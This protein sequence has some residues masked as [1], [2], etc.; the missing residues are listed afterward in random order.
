MSFLSDPNGTIRQRKPISQRRND[1][2]M[3]FGRDNT[4][5][6]GEDG[7]IE[8]LFELIPP[9]A[10]QEQSQDQSQDQQRPKRWCVDVGAWDGKHLSNTYSLLCERSDWSGVLI[11]AD[12][13]KF[14]H[15]TKLHGP[16]NNACLNITVSCLHNSTQSLSHILKHLAPKD[17]PKDFEL[18]IIDVDGPDYW[19]MYDLLMSEFRPKVICV[20]FN[21][22]MPHSL[23]YIQP[24]DDNIR[25][26]S[27]LPAI[28]MLASQFEY[29]LVETTCY[30][31]FYVDK[32]IYEEYVKNEIPFEPT[33]E[34]LHEITMG[35]TLYQLY[36]GRL[37]ITGCKKLLWHRIPIQ[38]EKMQMLEDRSFPFAPGVYEKQPKTSAQD[39]K[40][41]ESISV[42][43]SPYCSSGTFEE[44][45]KCS[46]AILETLKRDGF[47]FV[48]GT[49]M[50]QGVCSDALKWTN[51]FL[52]DAPESVRRSCL[53]KDRARRGYSPQNTENFASLIGAKGPNDLVRKFRIGQETN[54]EDAGNF[55]L[56]QPNI[57]P[58]EEVWGKKNSEE[59]QKCV[60]AYYDSICDVAN[61]IVLSIRDGLKDLCDE[62]LTPSMESLSIGS[63][64]HTSILTLLNYRKGARHQGCKKTLI[65]AHTDVGVITVLLFDGGNSASLQRRDGD[66]WVDVKLPTEVPSDPIFVV[67]IGDCLSDLCRAKLPSTMHRVMPKS[68]P[69]PQTPRSSLGLFVGFESDQNLEINGER[70]TYE[71]W[72]RRR[73]AKAQGRI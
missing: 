24:R 66:N 35:T 18:I 25:H 19:L 73:I 45:K 37:K 51:N 6:S 14:H 2:L 49:G 67:N 61:S 9:N 58:A 56:M 41:F 72:R 12:E 59:F 26:G 27:S 11:E 22:T 3:K 7:I 63:E 60:Q 33:I 65:A 32:H 48:R 36:D 39:I 23:V 46:Q 29:Q 47:V 69:G 30:N 15:L 43:M 52:H 55:A 44:K 38:E 31:A 57:W 64:S 53:T 20:E 40:M 5:Q 28:D 13:E 21:P 62:A 42:D 16:L 1:G 34:S 71:E 70:M 54:R 10:T 17:L 8:R 4:S 68:G 50:S